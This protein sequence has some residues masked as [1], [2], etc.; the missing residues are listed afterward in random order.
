MSATI[1]MIKSLWKGE[2]LAKET[3]IVVLLNVHTVKLHS[4]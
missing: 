4:P 1:K 3:T 2:D